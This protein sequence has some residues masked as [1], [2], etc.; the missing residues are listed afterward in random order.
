LKDFAEEII[1]LTGTTQKIVYR[2]LPVD[3]PKQRRPDITKAKEIL[4][5][6]P[7]VSREEGLKKTYA[8]FQTLPQ[9]ELVKQPKEF[10][11]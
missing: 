3:D 4:G 5:W 2:E 9:E 7:K 11:K 10:Y 6:S 8:Y 1:R